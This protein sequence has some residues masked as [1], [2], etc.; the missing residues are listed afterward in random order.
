M[1]LKVRITSSRKGPKRG[2]MIG[3]EQ[4]VPT[5]S[6]IVID[7]VAYPLEGQPPVA[8]TRGWGIVPGSKP[9]K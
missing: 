9:G 1:K 2:A 4:G 7:S 8:R 5:S 3:P 6:G